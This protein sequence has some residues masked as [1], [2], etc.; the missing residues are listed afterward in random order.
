M[1]LAIFSLLSIK[2]QD[3]LI[4]HDWYSTSS[5]S[6]STVVA[7]TD[8]F[9]NNSN[10]LET[11]GDGNWRGFRFNQIAIDHTKTYRFSFWGKF[12]D[13]NPNPFITEVV[14]RDASGNTIQHI[15]RDGSPIQFKYVYASWNSANMI[16][17]TDTWYLFVGFINGSGDSNS[18]VGGVYDTTGNL[19]SPEPQQDSS[20]STSAQYLNFASNYKYDTNVGHRAYTFDPRI[21][22][23]T[24]GDDS[25][26][27]LIN[28]GSQPDCST[29]PL[30]TE[31]QVNDGTWVQG[32]SSVTLEEGDKIV[33]SG[34]PN[35]PT[36]T[37]TTPSSQVLGDGYTIDSITASDTGIYTVT[38]TATGCTKTLE[39]VVNGSGGG[40]PP[41]SG[42]SPW[43]KTG[44]T[45]A[46]GD[47]NDNVAIGT[48]AVPNGY[49]MA[50][51]G[52]IIVE[53][54]RVELSGINGTWP[55]YVFKKDYELLTLEEIKKHIEEKGHLP[56]IPSAQEVEENG[57]E[58]GEMNRL[59]LEKIEEQMLYIL[60][61]KEELDFLKEEMKNLKK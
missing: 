20:W 61:Q 30:V 33:F 55:D 57:V 47:S 7:G 18:Y 19:V 34:N 45:V 12:S 3:P 16:P 23:V 38:D 1:V 32:A 17:Q 39:V 54:V 58:L 42:D 11:T 52:N 15:I 56:N 22:V 9:G 49:K 43:T 8:P 28:P 48:T 14:T 53:E 60:Q 2:A 50:V 36:Y 29:S 26:T 44:T 24:N 21:E 4:N 35:G 10:M 5:H 46:V 31:Y 13:I 51:D 37:I 41:P 6:G 25:V 40:N 27:D 59:L